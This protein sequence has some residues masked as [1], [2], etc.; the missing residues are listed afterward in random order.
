MGEFVP[1]SI[2]FLEAITDLSKNTTQRLN[3]DTALLCR[4]ATEFIQASD[5][6]NETMFR[7]DIESLK[8]AENY[9]KTKE[10]LQ[11]LIASYP[12][13]EDV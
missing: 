8:S 3:K 6:Y 11:F 10:A 5:S 7:S 2:G 13:N 1:T 12:S 9:N 4:A